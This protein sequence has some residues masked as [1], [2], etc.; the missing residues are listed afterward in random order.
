MM[1]QA[2]WMHC[3]IW[4]TACLFGV[5]LMA[6]EGRPWIALILAILAVAWIPSRIWSWQRYLQ[7]REQEEEE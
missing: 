1:P 5:F 7:Q 4:V 6:S 2:L 3:G